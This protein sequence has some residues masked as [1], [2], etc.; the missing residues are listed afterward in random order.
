[1][2][3]QGYSITNGKCKGNQKSLNITDDPFVYDFLLDCDVGVLKMCVVGKSDV[4]TINGLPKKD[5]KG[6]VCHCNVGWTNT[7]VRIA[8]ISPTL[9]TKSHNELNKYLG[10]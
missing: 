3:S 9:F 4:Y 5:K 6:W 2:S 8:K 1:M 7:Q 10:F